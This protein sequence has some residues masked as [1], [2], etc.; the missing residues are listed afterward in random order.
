MYCWLGVFFSLNFDLICCF[1]CA[2]LVLPSA[3]FEECSWRFWLLCG[4]FVVRPGVLTARLME[5]QNMISPYFKRKLSCLLDA[6]LCSRL[7][8]N[9]FPIVRPLKWITC[10]WEIKYGNVHPLTE[11]RDMK[12]Y[13]IPRW[14]GKNCLHCL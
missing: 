8:V 2:L 7:R 9:R 5:N 4:G 1:R 6:K 13:Q 3:H 12:M 10:K 11:V 14:I